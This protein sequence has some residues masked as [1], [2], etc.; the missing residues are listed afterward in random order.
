MET[1]SEVNKILRIA[2][3]FCGAGGTSTGA[4]EAAERLGYTVELTAINHWDVAIETHQIN[5][6]GARVLCTGMDQVNPRD[7]FREGELNLLWASP[8]CTHHSVARGGKPVSEQGRSTAWCVIKWADALSPPIILVEN[9]PEFL[10]WGGI[11]A[12]GRPM[13]SKK[14]ETFRAWKAALESLGYRVDHRILGA[15]DY[16]DPTTRRRLFVQAIRGRRRIAW[17]QPTHSP[18]G[19]TDLISSTKR[20]A[21]AREKVID[22]TIKGR[23]ID[24]M[25]PQKRYGGLPL[26]PNSLTR[27]N[28]GFFKHGLKNFI[29]EACHGNGNDLK[30]DDRRIHHLDK[31]LG[32]VPCSNRFASIEVAMEPFLIPAQS[33][34][35]RTRSVDKPLQTVTCESR[36]IGLAEPFLLCLEHSGRNG[37]AARSVDKP[38]PTITTAKGGAI[39]L[40]ES[41]LISLRGTSREQIENSSTSIDAPVPAITAGGG[42]IGL[43][44]P[45]LFH[46]NHQGGERTRSVDEPMPTVCGNRGEMGLIEAALLPQQ[47]DGRLRPVSEPCPTVATAGAIA[48]IEAFLVKYYGTAGAQSVDEPLDT[49]TT[50]DRH[51]LVSP[52]VQIDG[53]LFRVRYRYRMLKFHELAAAQGFKRDYVF[54]GN[55]TQKVKQ[56]GNAVPRRLARAIVNAVLVQ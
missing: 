1:R 41:F 2:D 47:S 22:W 8:E 4:I 30:G 43:V 32:T 29:I 13:K 3:L 15:A 17:P 35:G 46:T 53:Q 19:G 7:L 44:E 9:V 12:N 14:G 49:V 26:S 24:E 50:K 38:M 10:T 45:F 48:L 27:I 6:P 28:S 34:K 31:P 52:E 23:W 16:G 18:E 55:I 21:T 11:G 36:G 37:D 42:H 40:V 51:A 25:K 56:I 39:G 54:A 20:W 5:H 33:G